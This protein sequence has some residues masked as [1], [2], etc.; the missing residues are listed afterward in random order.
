[1]HWLPVIL[2]L[3][4]HPAMAEQYY[5]VGITDGDT[6]TV[7]DQ[8]KIQYKVRLT[9]IDTPERRQPWGEKARQALAEK[10]FNKNVEIKTQ[11][12]DRY[13]RVLGRIYL[14]DRDIHREMVSEGHAWVY[15]QYMTDE[16][17]LEDESEARE[18]ELGLWG[19]GNAVPP[20][21]WR[22]GSRNT[23]IQPQT[24]PVKCGV[25]RYCREMTSCD[26]AMFYHEECGLTRLDGDKDGV[27]CEAICR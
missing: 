21:E 26:E 8:S 13:G 20:W 22:R 16:S 14:G 4:V 24:I 27:P 3:L 1:M 23:V 5:V 11:G 12:T 18:S 9:E 15:R 7:I 17:L 10:V 6:V 25:K 2:F 19:L